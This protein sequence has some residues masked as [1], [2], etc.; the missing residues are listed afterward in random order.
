MTSFSLPWGKWYYGKMPFGIKNG[1]SHFQ[2]VMT[3][4][5]GN[6]PFADVYIDDVAVHSQ[7]FEEH[8]THLETVLNLL[9]K[10]KLTASPEK[11]QIAKPRLDF[12][13]HS[14]GSG[15]IRPQ[16]CKT[17]SFQSYVRPISIFRGN[18]FLSL[19]Y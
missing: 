18:G 5:L 17:S 1:P 3:G 9:K 7:T 8:L 16:Q 19:L 15:E 13:G 6:M 12:L 10:K 14:I 11:L 4:L 2:R